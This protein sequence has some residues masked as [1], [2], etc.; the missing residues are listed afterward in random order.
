M[1]LEPNTPALAPLRG[2]E[3]LDSW[4]RAF[5]RRDPARAAR[6]REA[7]KLFL[8]EARGKSD[9]TEHAY[10]HRS[11]RT[12]RAYRFA[13]VEFFEF[14]ARAR[15]RVVPPHEVT[16]RDAF[17]YAE[18]L[19]NRGSGT[20][21]FSLEAEKLR[22]GDRE[23]ERE[24][25]EA[26][27]R[28][29][30]AN[31]AEIA[32]ALPRRI[33]GTHPPRGRQVATQVVDEQWLEQ[34]L[35]TLMRQDVITRSPTL[36]EI[37]REQPRAGFDDPVDPLVYTYTCVP[38]RPVARSTI[39]LRLSA[40]SSFW[41]VMQKGENTEKGKALLDYNVFDDAL[42]SVTK[43]LKAA[44][45][46][47]SMSK[48]PS[49]ELVG[50]VLGIADGARLVQ[51][52]NVALIWF[53]LLTGA[54]ISEAL[55]MRRGE[56]PT[57]GDRQRYPGWLDRSSDPVTV[58][59]LR[60]GA[61]RQPLALPPFVLGALSAFWT[62]MAELAGDDPADP[63]YR[64]RL[65]LREPDAP[66]FPPVGMWGSNQLS[67]D[68]EHGLWSYRRSLTRQGVQKMLARLSRAAGLSEA[69][70]RRIHPHG[71]R[72]LAAEAIVAEG[73][74]REAQVILGHTSVQTTE[75]YLPSQVRDVQRSAQ[76]EILDYLAKRG[77]YGERAAPLAVPEPKTIRTY[78]RPAE[79]LPR[80]ARRQEP[81]GELP[82]APAAPIALLP[83]APADVEGDLVAIGHEVSSTGPVDVYE[84]MA[85][86]RKPPDLAWS[87][88][89][90]TKWI[91]RHYPDVP[92]GF[93]VGKES[94]LP[95]WQ[96]DAP[97]PWP[98]LAPAQAYPELCPELG[99][100]RQLERLYDEW[101]ETQPSA[102]LALAQWLY[103]LGM[104]TVSL[105]T[106]I[107]GKTS[108]VSFSAHATVGE[109]LRAHLDSWLVGW[110]EKNAHT[111]QTVQ[112]R[113]VSAPMPTGSERQAEY[114]ERVRQ[115]LGVA[116]LIPAV[117]ELPAWYFEP[118]PV[119]AIY[120][121]SP[122]EF[123]AFAKWIEK[124]T[125]QTESDVRTESRDEQLEFF[126]RAEQS[127]A[128]RAERY[129]EQFYSVVDEIK[130]AERDRSKPEQ[131]QLERQ[132]E[133]L[134]DF[135]AKEFGIRLPKKALD[136]GKRRERTNR[137]LAEAF[138]QEPEAVKNVL[139]DSRMFDRDAFRIDRSGHTITHTELF[140]ERFSQR[141]FG[142]DSECV[143][144][145]IARSLWEKARGWQYK[146]KPESEQRRELF[147]TLLAELAYVV[148][149]PPDVEKRL[150]ERGVSYWRPQEIADYIN[151]RLA[152]MAAGEEVDDGD[153]EADILE[154]YESETSP[155]ARAARRTTT[156]NL[157]KNALE[158]T[159]HPLRLVAAAFWPV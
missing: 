151:E 48:R 39:A 157:R 106:E 136:P 64:Y 84:A 35:I 42:A 83:P 85:A 70:R 124:L 101:S 78:G 68:S 127:D 89:P 5:S 33:I 41:R 100:L 137:L 92:V 111:F 79:E 135:I 81:A 62:H 105:D 159:P 27:R 29:G 23:D 57:E 143:M 88:S 156:P 58:V 114:W 46:E 155:P 132:R 97:M 150:A 22:D 133:A 153:M 60:K 76:N 125:G 107:A 6:Y 116:G 30:A 126:E 109:D 32:R 37:R 4:V 95:W 17:E 43:N 28:A 50:R 131:K 90:Q 152:R 8:G 65:L 59:L 55:G 38:V 103:F 87:S 24:V 1:G 51:K 122:K 2:K 104:L 3:P 53:L 26:M 63:S 139:G 31:I 138:G 74:I 130:A 20:W 144:R 52:R 11:P 129:I 44:K 134:R 86:G 77:F 56:P 110:F 7:L 19:A 45:R 18:W 75:E 94:L 147:V 61:F 140:R 71:F 121:R 117:P 69:E 113:F 36:D 119:H 47:A 49:A 13:V 9:W 66:L 80:A 154:V 72:H 21:D 96:K 120:D 34:V 12:L 128:A 16:R 112:R 142:R 93:G 118:D 67:E 14:V 73:S 102:T 25:Y 99:F 91:E 82:G 123:G 54:R 146:K 145:R 148:P 115:S 158:A 108:W 98:V 40:L 15:G 10:V 141:H 149:C